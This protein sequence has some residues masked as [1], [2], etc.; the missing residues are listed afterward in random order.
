[1]AAMTSRIKISAG[2]TW[3]RSAARRTAASRHVPPTARTSSLRLSTLPTA[4]GEKLV[5]RVFDPEV[6]VKDFAELGFSE[7]DKNRWKQMIGQPNASSSWTGPHGLG[8]DH[9]LYSTLKTLATPDVNVCTIED[10]IEMI[11][12]LVQPDAG[13]AGDRPGLRRRRARASCAR[14]LTSSWWARSATCH[15]EMAIQAALTGHLVLSTLHTTTRRARSRGCST[16]GVA[17]YCSIDHTRRDAQRLVRI[18]CKHCKEKIP[19]DEGARATSW[20]TSS[21]RGRRAADAHLRPVGCLECR[22]HR[23]HGAHRP[24]EILILSAEI[25]R[26]N[27]RRS[28][29]LARSAKSRPRKA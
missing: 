11:G 15:R 12:A 4:F 1:M 26:L 19:F 24:V 8:Q 29:P 28:R 23:L 16:W 17:P 21:R 20:R 7:E 9:T 27:H 25:R 5:M 2:W 10:P 14:T 13:A 18:L 6:I 22:K 3:S